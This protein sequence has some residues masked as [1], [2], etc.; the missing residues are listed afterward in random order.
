MKRV[1]RREFL[2]LAGAGAV[3]LGVGLAAGY[4]LGAREVQPAPAEKKIRALWIYVGPITDVGWTAAH[5]EAKENVAKAFPWLEAKHIEKVKEEEAKSIIEAELQRQ[6]Y[7]AV[8]AT[9][10]GFK[11]AVKELAPRYPKTMFYHCS[12]EWEEFKDLPNVSTYFVEFYQ[13]YYLNGIAAGAVTESCKIGYVPAFLIPEV[14]RHINAF[15]LGAVHGAKLMGKCGG[16]ERVEIYSTRP[17][18]S[19]FAPDKA[20]EFTA[21][22]VE[23]YNVDVVAFTEDTTAVL[24]KAEEYYERGRKVFSFSHYN[25]MFSYYQRKGR[26]LRSHLTGQVADWTPIYRDLLLKLYAGAYVKEDIWARVGDYAP[27]R[28]R[29]PEAQSLA[30]KPEGA[31]YLA[32]ISDQIP[33]KARAEIVRLYELMKELLFEPFVG[34][35]RGYKIDGEGRPQESV[36]LKVDSGVRLGRD[37]LWYMDWFHEKIISPA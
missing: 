20:K 14:V 6:H 12:G 9:S 4:S 1:N 5:H 11:T 21:Y 30:G 28:W 32:P 24:D 2:K 7:D 26:T 18:L 35:I 13:L 17:L 10:Y 27:I 31:A 8:F 22:L 25:D 33:A 15:A 3:A 36:R 19:W 29:K 34:P 37:E 23:R 16:G